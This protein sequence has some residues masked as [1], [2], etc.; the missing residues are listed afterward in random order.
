MGYGGSC[1]ECGLKPKA[2]S[3]NSK[4]P[5]SSLMK[6]HLLYNCEIY[7]YSIKCKPL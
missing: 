5:L 7:S 3:K 1:P 6:T 2:E 4:I